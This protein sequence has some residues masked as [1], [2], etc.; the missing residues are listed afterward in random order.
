MTL[1]YKDRDTKHDPLPVQSVSYR[2]S[3]SSEYIS[4]HVYDKESLEFKLEGGYRFANR[5]RLRGGWAYE[6]IDRDAQEVDESYKDS[7]DENRFWA[8]LKM[9]QM[10]ALS[11]RLR[12]Q[13]SQLDND[14][15]H[16]RDEHVHNEEGIAERALPFFLL[17]RDQDRYSISADYMANSQLSF[18]ASYEYIQD[19]FDNDAYGL[20]E[21]ES[22]V[23]NLAASFSPSEALAFTVYGSH[24]EYQLEQLSL[25]T[26]GS[27]APPSAEWSLEQEDEA[28]TLGFSAQWSA[29]PDKLDVVFDYSWMKADSAYAS[30][31]GTLDGAVRECSGAPSYSGFCTGSMPDVSN[32]LQRLNLKLDYHY[33]EQ[34]DISARYVYEHRRMDDWSWGASRAYAAALGFYWQDPSYDSHAV[35]VAVRYKF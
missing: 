25:Y 8:E 32:K 9:P 27:S 16:E 2:G 34:T 14:I 30:I 26:Q 21:R 18:N 10:G 35:V 11:V 15:S 5:M 12:G 24:E 19:D 1:D 6:E 3:V 29:I 17:A 33:N 20:E 23:L 22:Q 31:A 28:D 13:Y 4:T 7:T